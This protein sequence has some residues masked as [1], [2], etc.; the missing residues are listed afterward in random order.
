M[1]IPGNCRI[2][3]GYFNLPKHLE[4]T[5]ILLAD[6]DSATLQEADEKAEWVIRN[7]QDQAF[8]PPNYNPVPDFSEDLAAICLDMLYRV[9]VLGDDEPEVAT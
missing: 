8:W 7:L 6:W 4:D 3:L 5:G 1:E 9:P 2:Q